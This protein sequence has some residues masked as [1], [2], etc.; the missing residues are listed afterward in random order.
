MLCK[1]VK[2][3]TT[4]FI[5]ENFFCSKETDRWGLTTPGWRLMLGCEFPKAGLPLQARGAQNIRVSVSH[6]RVPLSC[7]PRHVLVAEKGN[8]PMGSTTKSDAGTTLNELT[9]DY[10]RPIHVKPL[11][12]AITFSCPDICIRLHSQ[13]RRSSIIH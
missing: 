2:Y 10:N 3:I 1:N 4:P 7:A 11:F 6:T 9:V 5:C 8:F 13:T 12:S